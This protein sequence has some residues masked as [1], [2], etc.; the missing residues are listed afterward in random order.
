MENM[1]NILLTG[2]D[3]SKKVSGGVVT[4]IE[5]LLN[6]QLRKNYNYTYQKIEYN[7]KNVFERALCLLKDYMKLLQK[8]K[9]CKYKL[10]HINT[11]MYLVSLMRIIPAIILSKLFKIKIV[12]QLHGGRIKEIKKYRKLILHFLIKCDKILILS[13]EQANQFYKLNSDFINRIE[14]VPNFINI[15]EFAMIETKKEDKLTF[16]YL[17]RIVE[18]KGIYVLINA[19]KN[20]SEDEKKKVKF[21]IAGDGS[22]LSNAKK[23]C[24]EYKINDIVKFTG[25]LRNAKKREVLAKSDVLILPSWSEAFPY[26]A[27]EAMAYKMPIISTSSGAMQELIIQGKNGFLILY[28]N[29]DALVEKIRFFINNTEE[30]A[31]MGEYNYEV[32][33]DNY[34]MEKQGVEKFSKIYSN[35]A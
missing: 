1:E 9:K 26:V 22:D 33:V 34:T 32:L 31:R 16:L 8:M 24:Y 19:I 25:F 2:L 28:K 15:T 35:L 23:L 30:I 3:I 13:N 21:I 12:L 27:L 4:H 29:V 17:G 6:S 14:V 7:G 18:K 20:L 11:S 10:I 5:N